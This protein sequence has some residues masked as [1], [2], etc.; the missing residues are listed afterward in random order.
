MKLSLPAFGLKKR[1]PALIFLPLIFSFFIFAGSL[2]AQ[3]PVDPSSIIGKVVCGYQCWFTATGD[4]SPV[5]QW[6]HWSPTNPPQAGIAPNPNPNLTFDAYP[7]VSIYSTASLFQTNFASQGNGQ[8]AQLFS[9]YKQDVVDTHFA[10]MQANGIDGVAFQ[11]FIWEVLVDP[12]FKA[13]RDSDEVHV[14]ASAEK[15][16]R[17]FYLTY[18]L[19]GLGNVPA[20]S[21]QVRLDSVKGDWQNDMI[22]NLNMTSSPMYAHQGGKPV[23]QI[24]GIGYNPSTG[25]SAQQDSLIT[26]FEQQGCYVIIGVPIDW[27]KGGGACV[28][29]FDSVQCSVANMISPW[30]VGAYSNQTSTDS[31]KTNYLVPDL[32]YC[33]R[34]GIGYQPIIFPGFSWS[35]WNGGAQNQIPRNL[36]N[37]LWRQAYDLRS[38]NIKTAEIAMMDEFDEGTAILPMADGYNMIPTNQY[39]VTTSADGTYLSSDFYLRLAS[40][41]TRQ[42]NQLDAINAIMPVAYSVGPIFF[43]TSNEPKYDAQPNWL[44]TTNQKSNVS[45]Y[46]S[47]F[48]NPSCA[49]ATGHPR[50]GQYSL[51]VSGRDRSATTSNAYFQVWDV[52]IPV[53]ANTE[54]NFWTYPMNTL[55]RYVSVDLLMTDGTTLRSTAAVDSSGLSMKP[56]TGRGK[57]NTWTKTKCNI[58]TWLNGK[59]IDKIL[60]GYDNG[61]STGDFSSYIDDIS[62]NTANMQQLSAAP[63][64]V[65]NNFEISNI[66]NKQHVYL[67]NNPVSNVVNLKLERI[68]TDKV[69]VRLYDASEKLVISKEFKNSG[70]YIQLDIPFVHTAGIYFVETIVDGISYTNKLVK[71]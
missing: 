70:N 71:Q 10:L 25:T 18:D 58:G 26:W 33:N 9:S 55:G 69:I 3:A 39:F 35:N 41:V 7:D 29:G 11:R 12:R 22:G 44:S 51:Y 32:A 52:N 38:L 6:T 34:K 56:A 27:R 14:R 1:L 66:E 50:S 57:L 8:P 37:F 65:S 61:P 45:A 42:I 23:V 16:Q 60:V 4:G 17:M 67:L 20:A 54:L 31:Y 48:G 47:N 15:Y 24:W 40:K 64:A 53:T 28:A 43:R 30:A 62:V 46:G 68:P 63:L 13:N 21:D 2:R 36:G 19:T 5:N 49:T 59:T